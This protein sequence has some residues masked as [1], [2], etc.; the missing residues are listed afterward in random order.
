MSKSPLPAATAAETTIAR[1]AN[2]LAAR[3]EFDRNRVALCRLLAGRSSMAKR[4]RGRPPLP[5]AG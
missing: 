5:A 4:K 3:A 1:P 2:T